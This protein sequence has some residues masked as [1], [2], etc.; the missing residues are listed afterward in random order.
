MARTIGPSRQDQAT[1][2]LLVGAMLVGLGVNW[3]AHGALG[4]LRPVVDVGIFLVITAVMLGVRTPDLRRAFLSKGK[5]TAIALVTNFVV[6]PALA[7]LIGW[8]FLRHSPDLWSGI[9]LYA[10]T[11]CV[12]WYLIFI[13]AAEGDIAWGAALLPW[14][15]GLQIL[16]MPVYMWLLVGHVLFLDAGTL[17]WSVGLFFV[18]P[19]LLGWGLQWLIL[20]RWGE[21]T[22]LGPVKKAL[23]PIKLWALV[24]VILALFA[25]QPTL[26]LH[27]LVLLV[28]VI[29]TIFVFFAVVFLLALLNGAWAHLSYEDNVTL[30]F[31]TTARNSEVVIGVAMV[32]FPGHPLV[33]MAILIGPLVELP[34]L[35]LLARGLRRLRPVLW[36]ERASVAG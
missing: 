19:F 10:L 9:I 20:R 21:A 14:N 27:S 15:L 8:V 1:P 5:P 23:E 24:A 2:F 6:I 35:L 29:G 13:D 12:G 11:P 4:F 31:T 36:A 22:F 3:L 28:A 30:T 25:S 33:Y 17:L 18:A 34:V 7:W 16:L 32:A 26:K